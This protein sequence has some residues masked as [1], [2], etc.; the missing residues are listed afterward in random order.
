MKHFLSTF[1]RISCWPIIG[2]IFLG[3]AFCIA[4]PVHGILVSLGIPAAVAGGSVD[5]LV[6]SRWLLMISVPLLANGFYLVRMNRIRM[7]VCLRLTSRVYFGNYLLGGCAVHAVLWAFMLCCITCWQFPVTHIAVFFLLLLLQFLLWGFVSLL[8]YLVCQK[9]AWSGIAALMSAGIA[10]L[11][12]AYLPQLT[13]YMPS[14]W[15]MYARSDLFVPNG[16]PATQMIFLLI[17]LCVICL[18]VLSSI[19]R[20]FEL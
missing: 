8:L 9:A 1:F 3:G 12:S 16:E 7:F 14:T 11:I 5:S 18:F 17:V 6:F 13:N 10:F 19:T 15:G 4:H 2:I 20:R